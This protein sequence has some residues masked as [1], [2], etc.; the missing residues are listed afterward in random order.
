MSFKV[1]EP[2]V[3]EELKKLNLEPKIQEE[4]NQVYCMFK[5]EKGGEFPMFVRLLH[6]GELVQL[7]TFFPCSVQKDQFNDI[8]RFL[9]IVNKELD[10]PGFCFD[11]A[12]TTVFYRLVIP[13]AKKELSTEVFS[14]VIN[15][16]RVVCTTFAPAIEAMASGAMTLQDVLNKA[17][18]MAP[19]AP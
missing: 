19:K 3:L 11:E 9:H 4:T 16:S 1:S 10:V 15:T 14:A 13:T 5:G 17:A 7:I 2:N 12:S 6:E 18:A 8:A